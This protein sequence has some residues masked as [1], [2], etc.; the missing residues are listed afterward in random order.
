MSVWI[1]DAANSW[2]ISTLITTTLLCAVVLMIRRPVA[3]HFGAQAAYALWALPAL[4]MVLPPLPFLFPNLTHL[5]NPSATDTQTLNVVPV[6][7][8]GASAVAGLVDAAPAAT[9]A[10][11]ATGTFDHALVMVMS[12]LPSLILALWGVGV[13]AHLVLQWSAHRR[14]LQQLASAETLAWDGNVRIVRSEQVDTP[15]SLGL[16]DR[17][18]V[19]PGEDRLPLTPLE[20]ALAVQ[21]ELTHHRR[22]DL[23]INAFAVL[24]SALHWFNPLV[25]HAWRAFRFDQ[26]AACDAAVLNGADAPTRGAYARALAKAA[27]GQPSAFASPM[28][29]KAMVKERLVMLIAPEHSLLRRRVGLALGGVALCLGMGATASQLAQ[30]PELDGV[31]PI[32]AAPPPP[33]P[34]GYGPN[35]ASNLPMPP[36]PPMPPVAV[37]TLGGQPISYIHRRWENGRE[38]V[39]VRTRDGRNYNFNRSER[40]SEADLSRAIEQADW[41]AEEAQRDAAGAA[42]D[43]AAAGRDAE[44]AGADA[45]RAADDAQRNAMNART[46]ALRAAADARRE[47]A[48]AA[49]EARREGLVAAAE[50]RRAGQQAAAEAR[51]AVADA[52]ASMHA[53]YADGRY[54]T[55]DAQRCQV[56]RSGG[57]SAVACA[58]RPATAAERAAAAR[59]ISEAQSALSASEAQLS[60]VDS[61]TE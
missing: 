24:F 59:A 4:R 25:R 34:G 42:R 19:L 20:R 47:G 16:Y 51:R 38:A 49:A 61:S 41:A 50:A 36:R 55:H 22:G 31:P 40:M 17:M 54:R 39:T 30:S 6:S 56:S 13:V 10:A 7:D 15:L 43:A 3:R 32:S 14:L 8:G 26:E 33:A 21:H 46:D 60:S 28:L 9:A 57:A 18:V 35:A 45:R 27:S 5:L 58:S 23:W 52:R 29:G 1:I 11:Q 53:S 12:A 48:R 37:T 2:L 44:R